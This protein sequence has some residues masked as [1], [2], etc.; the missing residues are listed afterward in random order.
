M[1]F[2]GMKKLLI[3]PMLALVFFS[4]KKK[5]AADQASIDNGII[6]TYISSHHLAAK[7]TGSG[8]YYVVN[9]P[10]TG[11]SI[12]AGSTVTVNYKGYLS[13][14][15]VFDQSTS[16]GITISLGQVIQGWQEGIPLYKKGGSGILLIPSSLGYGAQA[17]GSIPANSVLIFD[18]TVLP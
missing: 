14:G 16:S 10:G 9:A 5:A 15:T 1:Y 13:N 11:A 7:A 17:T 8:L 4:C 12:A 2:S 18:I 3:L 6:T